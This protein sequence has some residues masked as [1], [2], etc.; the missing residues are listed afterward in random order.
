MTLFKS[1]VALAALLATLPG[2]GGDEP[3]GPSPLGQAEAPVLADAVHASLSVRGAMLSPEDAVIDGRW[4][5][6]R[7]IYKF[8]QDFQI[9]LPERDAACVANGDH[10]IDADGDGI[11][12]DYAVTFGCYGKFGSVFTYAVLGGVTVNDADDH[13]PTSGYDIKW[14]GFSIDRTFLGT[15]VTKGLWLDGTLKLVHDS[16]ATT[17]AE[18]YTVRARV[19]KSGESHSGTLASGK[20]ALYQPDDADKPFAAGNVLW[21]ADSAFTYDDVTHHLATR[22]DPSLHFNEACR[23][24]FPGRPGW[25]G[26]AVLYS[27]GS[28]LRIAY[29]GCVNS[30]A[31]LDGVPVPF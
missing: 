4:V 11:P 27:D 1:S 18:N 13:D 9:T 12:V 22:T 19:T 26:G 30:T 28:T 24:A 20:I 3:T 2:C 5:V 31:T 16:M 25:D 29:D 6:A 21:L 15:G 17:L 14:A 8:L 23:T 7:P 10:W